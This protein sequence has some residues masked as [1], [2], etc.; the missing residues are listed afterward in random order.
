L[1]FFNGASRLAY[2]SIALSEDGEI[3]NEVFNDTSSGKTT[4]LELYD[5]DDKKARFVKITGFGNSQSTWNSIT[6]TR[7]NYTEN[8]TFI[9]G[10]Y[11][12][13]QLII[14]PQPLKENVI[15]LT[16]S[17]PEVHS[18]ELKDLNGRI[19]ESGTIDTNFNQIEFNKK[20]KTG[21]YI[22]SLIGEKYCSTKLIVN[23]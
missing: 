12:N 9:G 4:E 16:N 20:P 21:T 7:I 14:Y 22:L 11:Q 3:F 19:I 5:F 6:E 17:I 23:K 8:A 13:S 15:H 18:W 1:A 10:L 2:F